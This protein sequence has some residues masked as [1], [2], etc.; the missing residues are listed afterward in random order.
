MPTNT[1]DLAPIPSFDDV[2]FQ[3]EE[4]R[5]TLPPIYDGD[6]AVE[7]S[8]HMAELITRLWEN[9]SADDAQLLLGAA[10]ILGAAGYAS[11]AQ[12]IALV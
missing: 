12:G 2:M 3:M 10:A 4:V 7:I 8:V 1:L 6:D 11:L 9:L 5:K